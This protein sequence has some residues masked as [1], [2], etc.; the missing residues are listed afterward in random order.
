MIQ[1]L[2]F[3][4]GYDLGLHAPGHFSKACL[5]GLVRV[6]GFDILPLSVT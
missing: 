1:D 3:P 4:T 2:V 6:P 5:I